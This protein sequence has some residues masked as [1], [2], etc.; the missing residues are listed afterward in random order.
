LF[1][2]LKAEVVIVCVVINSWD[3]TGVEQMDENSYPKP[4]RRRRIGRL[5]MALAAGVSLAAMGLVLGAN[6]GGAI[7]GGTP[8][9]SGSAPWQVS[10]Q[11]DEGHFCGATVIS[12][13]VI[14]TAAHCT[15]GLDATD[16]AVRAGVTGLSDTSA[17]S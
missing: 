11:D 6:P 5:V 16:I 8:A 1:R 4:N 3:K 12:A 10:L 13:R 15:E 14:V 7:V 9:P 2:L 17:Q